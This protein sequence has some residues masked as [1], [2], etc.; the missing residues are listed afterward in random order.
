[1]QYAGILEE[2]YQSIR[3]LNDRLSKLLRVSTI[4]LGI[5]IALVLVFGMLDIALLVVI[6]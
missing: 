6:C 1:M 3:R 5:S 4:I 2:P